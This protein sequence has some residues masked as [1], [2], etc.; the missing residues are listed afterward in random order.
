M[1]KITQEAINAFINWEKFSKSNM[2]VKYWT[3]DTGVLFLKL[4]W[5]AIAQKIW[6]KISISNAGW[7]STTTKERLNG[8]PWVSIQQKKGLGTWM[9]LN[10]TALGLRYRVLTGANI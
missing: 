4:H 3:H 1:R 2:Q 9:E 10:G 8:I 5:N 6:S 7:F